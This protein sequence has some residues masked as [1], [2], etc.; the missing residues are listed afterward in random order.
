LQCE[1]VFAVPSV[2]KPLVHFTFSIAR[3]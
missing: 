3:E 1:A 2:L